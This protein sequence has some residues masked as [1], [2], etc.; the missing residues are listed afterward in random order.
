MLLAPKVFP[1]GAILSKVDGRVT[2]VRKAPQ[3]GSFITVGNTTVYSPIARTVKVKV[4]DTVEAGD[5]LTN[6]VP[7]PM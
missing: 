4:G 2:E 6:G 7:N 5:M 1:G 3:G